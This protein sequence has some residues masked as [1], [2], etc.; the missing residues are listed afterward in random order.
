MPLL[1]VDFDYRF[2][3]GAAPGLTLAHHLQGGEVVSAV[4]LTEH[5]MERF[6]I[7]KVSVQ[8]HARAKR[9]KLELPGLLD[10]AVLDFDRRRMILVWR[11][12]YS[13]F[14]NEPAEPISAQ[15]RFEE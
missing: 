10:T 1:P 2:F 15:V 5:G 8:F 11:T 12:K 13:V 9:Q 7:P 6:E 4:N 14:M 3:N